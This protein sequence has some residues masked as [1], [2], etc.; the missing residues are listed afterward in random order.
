MRQFAE[1]YGISKSA[2]SE[3]FIR[4]SRRK[5]KQLLERDLS[6][7]VF[8]AIYIDDVEF[9]GQHLV[10]AL[11]VNNDGQKKVL[12]MRQGATE[13]AVVV[14][15]LLSDLAARGIDFAEPRL[16]V[17]DGAKALVKAVRQHAGR[18]GID[19]TLSVAQAP[20]RRRASE[21]RISR[22]CGPP[23]GRRL[24]DDVNTGRPAS[25]RATAP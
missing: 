1:A 7:F 8:C 3:H 12:G 16:Y 20:Q 17:I 22:R 25:V 5:V 14:S 18:V 2:V 4:V 13:N 10:V 21:R 15:A 11:G 24:S 9:K 23:T 19:P 6:A